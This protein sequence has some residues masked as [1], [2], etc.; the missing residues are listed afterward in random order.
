MLYLKVVL[1]HLSKFK[2]NSIIQ[3]RSSLLAVCNASFLLITFGPS[4]ITLTGSFFRAT[5]DIV[6]LMISTPHNSLWG[7]PL[8]EDK[9]YNYTTRKSEGVFSFCPLH[10]FPLTKMFEVWLTPTDVSLTSCLEKNP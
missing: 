1:K 9:Y 3:T 7:A 4:M 5:K 8:V 10:L 6:Q 2:F